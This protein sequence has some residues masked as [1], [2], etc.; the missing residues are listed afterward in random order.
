MGTGD[1]VAGVGASAAAWR[2][3]S[4]LLAYLR[5]GTYTECTLGRLAVGKSISKPTLSPPQRLKGFFLWRESAKKVSAG[6]K[7]GGKRKRFIRIN[8]KTIYYK[9]D[10]LIKAF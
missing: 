10:G 7:V 5:R 3:T 9:T 2:T 6:V 8:G 1:E 4:K